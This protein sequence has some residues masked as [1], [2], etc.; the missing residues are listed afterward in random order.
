MRFKE[1]KFNIFEI[2]KINSD[3]NIK[4][5]NKNVSDFS[6]V[7]ITYNESK[8]AIFQNNKN[9]KINEVN[10]NNL[11]FFKNSNNQ[12]PNYNNR[13]KINK[14]IN[15]NLK[16]SCINEGEK[17]KTLKRNTNEEFFS[18]KSNEISSNPQFSNFDV[19]K[20]NTHEN[21]KRKLNSQLKASYVKKTL[22]PYKYYLCSI[23]IKNIDTTKKSIFFTRKFLS[24]YNFICQLFDI[25]SYLILQREFEIMKNTMIVGKFKDILENR[26]KIN[27]NDQSFNINM[28]ECLDARKFSILGRIKQSK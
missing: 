7:Q 17:N 1:K 10:N 8:N 24:V 16:N 22:F 4:K 3:K 21:D 15:N 23:F 18:I 25:S 14:N 5:F 9:I 26:Q 11:K 6:S 2:D 27:V 12:I 20:N 28:K 13:K 19:K